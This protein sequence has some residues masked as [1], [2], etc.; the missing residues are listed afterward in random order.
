MLL[1]TKDLVSAPILIKKCFGSQFLGCTL[2]PGLTAFF[3]VKF[4]E[5][6]EKSFYKLKNIATNIE[7]D[8]LKY[9]YCDMDFCNEKK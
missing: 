4:R 6:F 1:H 3:A 8:K 5:N 7:S 9:R 2:R